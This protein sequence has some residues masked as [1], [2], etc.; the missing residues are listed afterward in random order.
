MKERPL[1]RI[2]IFATPPQRQAKHD[3]SRTRP[4]SCFGPVC[5][6]EA[7]PSYR[8]VTRAAYH[9]HARTDMATCEQGLTEQFACIPPVTGASAC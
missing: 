8:L 6:N 1:A 7:P 3:C 4:A 5:E 9:G 2:S